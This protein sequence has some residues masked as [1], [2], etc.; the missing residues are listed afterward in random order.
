LVNY[1]SS[2]S[3]YRRTQTDHDE[4]SLGTP[5]LRH[6]IPLL[7]MSN[8]GREIWILGR[9]VSYFGILNAYVNIN[10]G[11]AVDPRYL[12]NSHFAI[13]PVRH[14]LS[15]N[16][17]PT[18]VCSFLICHHATMT[19]P[20]PSRNSHWQFLSPF[21]CPFFPIQL[22]FIFYLNCVSRRNKLEINL[23]FFLSFLTVTSFCL[24]IVDVELTVS[25]QAQWQTHPLGS[26]CTSDQPVAETSTWQHTT[27]ARDKHP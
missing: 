4:Q 6:C 21:P 3:P 20:F 5:G 11:I 8:G 18:S 16:T 23:S 12:S 13:S 22:N 9:K 2:L 27:L 19:H 24:L 14:P 7:F 10:C 26:L 25:D 17:I 15:N 1:N